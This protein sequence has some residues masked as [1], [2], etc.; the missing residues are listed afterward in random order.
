M[1]GSCL[2]AEAIR[3][4]LAPLGLALHGEAALALAF[5][6]LRQL[7]DLGWR[8]DVEPPG[9][10]IEGQLV[11]GDELRAH[12][13]HLRKQPHAFDRIPLQFLEILAHHRQQQIARPGGQVDGENLLV[14]GKAAGDGMHLGGRAG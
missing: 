4:A 2:S 7:S 11:R 1:R 10:R 13:H 5:L 14:I 3:V 6:V 8:E 9:A 12:A